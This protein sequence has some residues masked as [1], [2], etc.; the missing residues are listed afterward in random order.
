[1]NF[2]IFSKN[3]SK[4][5]VSLFSFQIGI[6]GSECVIE[7]GAKHAWLDSKLYVMKF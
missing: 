2:G 5:T 1:M 4:A 3:E 6:S 7:S